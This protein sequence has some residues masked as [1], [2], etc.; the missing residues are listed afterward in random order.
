[1]LKVGMAVRILNPDY[2][3]GLIGYLLMQE[4]PS[5]WLVKVTVE[6]THLPNTSEVIVLSLQESDFEILHHS[7]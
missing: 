4:S 7:L 5:R 3:K 1:M 2:V 6:Q